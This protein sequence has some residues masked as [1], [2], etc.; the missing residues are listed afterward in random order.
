MST[1][2][3]LS[4]TQNAYY[5]NVSECPLTAWEKRFKEGDGSIRKHGKRTKL[6]RIVVFLTKGIR[7]R[8]KNDYDAWCVL[9]DDFVEVIGLEKDFIDYIDNKRMLQAAQIAFLKSTVK[10]EGIEVRN[11]KHLNLVRKLKAKVDKFEKLN[12]GQHKTVTQILVALY[13]GEKLPFLHKGDLTVEEYFSIIK[14]DNKQ[15]A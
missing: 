2:K 13:R 15:A 6:G 14:S 1:K 7:Y 4:F 12:S 3:G 8:S 11:R 9:F 5:L 10:R